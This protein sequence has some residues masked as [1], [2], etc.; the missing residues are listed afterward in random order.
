MRLT[1]KLEQ[2]QLWIGTK[3]GLLLSDPSLLAAPGTQRSVLGATVFL[4]KSLSSLCFACPWL[5]VF[6]FRCSPSVWTL[7]PHS[8]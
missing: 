8:F 3:G 2:D 7:S 5:F 1:F 6:A 4:L